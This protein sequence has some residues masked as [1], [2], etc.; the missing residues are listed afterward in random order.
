MLASSAGVASALTSS[1]SQF[2]ETSIVYGSPRIMERLTSP[3][4]F[5]ARDIP[6]GA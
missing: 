3:S 4:V 6:A 1:L 2:N 5:A